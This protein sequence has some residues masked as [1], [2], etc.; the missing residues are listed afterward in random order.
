M[1]KNL[2]FVLLF[3][4]ALILPIQLQADLPKDYSPVS[5]SAS[6]QTYFLQTNLINVAISSD[7]ILS[8]DRV[9]FASPE[10]GYIWPAYVNQRLNSDFSAGIWIGAKVGP[11]RELRLAAALYA[12]HFSPG[13]IP[14]IGG[15][16]SSSVCSDPQFHPYMVS[17][18]DAGLVEGGTRYKIAG[19]RQY[20]MIYD[21]WANWPVSKGAP[22]VEV[23]GIPGYQPGFE[24]DRP[25]IWHS[26]ARPDEVIFNVYMDYTNCTNSNHASGTSLPG[27]TLPLGV[28]V[29]Q[30]S[31][32]YYNNPY[33]SM[34]FNMWRMINKSSQLWDSVYI[35]IVDD[36]DIGD[37]S[38][39]AAGCDSVN[40]AGFIYNMSNIEPSYGSGPPAQC[41]SILQSPLNYTGNISDTAKLPY[42]NYV[43][44]KQTGMSSYNIFLTAGSSCVVD[45]GSALP[46]YNFMRGK[47][48][49]GNTL[50]N[51]VTGK[52]T[53]Y[54]Y[55]GNSVNRTGWF[56]STAGDKRQIL[57]CG[58]FSMASGSEQFLVSAVMTARSNTNFNSIS[59]VITSSITAK[60]FYNNS[61]GGTPIGIT[62]T[63]TEVPVDFS[64]EQNFPNPFNPATTIRFTVM[65]NAK[66]QMSKVELTVYDAL[67][68]SVA[69]LVNDRLAA[70][71]Y[72][73][74][75]DA[76]N[77]PS[78]IYFYE[79]KT[80]GF[81][82]TKKMVMI[83]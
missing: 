18:I 48:G 31:F 66:V 9:T 58:P 40:Q 51:W 79:L 13:N 5:P 64:L 69:K 42:G 4:T 73:Y 53:K 21:S 19:N 82:K 59:S 44:Y 22:Y 50:I 24:S 10:A 78:G 63:S 27:G 26:T 68:R 11:S 57:N 65:P 83:K 56:D 7:G 55:S 6:V 46:A 74:E 23:N 14:I 49:C 20:L 16:P 60:D 38:D 52:P 62:Q 72:S 76:A 8:Y 1:N 3:L 41:Y 39:D 37:G 75:W 71:T 77:Y 80:E 70:G 33:N 34:Y 45:P 29:Q 35:A 67:G 28:E 30:L 17:L 47:D 32:S 81:T 2:L 43:G 54:R 36:A 12:S 25:G 15:V 61:F